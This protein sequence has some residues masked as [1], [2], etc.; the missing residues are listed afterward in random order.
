MSQHGGDV[1]KAAWF[2]ELARV[3]IQPRGPFPDES[4]ICNLFADETLLA[5]AADLVCDNEFKMGWS[6]AYWTDT[7]TLLGLPVATR[8][9]A[10]FN[11][12]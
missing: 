6:P 2:L 4:P 8:E 12:E 1:V 5:S 9:L 11:H 3:W 10:R 7:F